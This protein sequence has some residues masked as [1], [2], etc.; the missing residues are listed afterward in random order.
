[1]LSGE[2]AHTNGT[3]LPAALC[4][5]EGQDTWLFS[6]GLGST[7]GWMPVHRQPRNKG[8]GHSSSRRGSTCTLPAFSRTQSVCF[9]LKRTQ[10]EALLYTLRKY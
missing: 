7:V 5:A 10:T 2:R 8:G 9:A 3:T 6:R 4:P 1:M